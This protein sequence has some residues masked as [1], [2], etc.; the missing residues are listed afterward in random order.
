MKE[1][2]EYVYD[3]SIRGS[4]ETMIK[5][6]ELL[7]AAEEIK[8]NYPQILK[9]L[10]KLINYDKIKNCNHDRL[11][12]SAAY[13]LPYLFD[14][15]LVMT[16]NFDRV[17]EEVFDK[18]HKKFEKVITPYE[19]DL[20]TQSR[21]NNPRCLFKLHGDIGPDIHDIERLIFT[22]TQY[23]RAYANDGPLMQEL[24]QWFQSKKLLFLGCS[25][26]KDKTMGVLQQVTSKNPGLDHYAILACCPGDIPQR[27]IE[28]GNWGISA[29][30]YPDGRHEAVRVILER[31][32]EDTNHSAYEE[33]CRY[34]KKSV[35]AL[36]SANRFMYDSN[37][38][39][40]VG[41]EQEL[42]QLQ[43]FCQDTEQISW[44]AVAGS[45]GIGKSRLVYEFTNAQRE[46]GWKICWLK[47]SDYD[48]LNS[49][50]P[51]VD[52]CIVVMDDVQAH[53]QTIGDWIISISSRQRSEKL[54]I[55]L[56]ERNGKDLDSA[57]WAELMQSESPYDDTISSK[58]YCSDFLNL[59]PL[60]DDELKDIMMD[61]AKVSGKPLVDSEHTDRLL[62]TLK[63]IDGDLQRPIYAL[64]ITDAWCG[65]KDPA[66]WSKEQVLDTL[67]M[68]ELKF[69]YCR[70]CSLSPD[71]ISKETRSE[72]ENLLAQS[73]TVPFL[74]LDQIAD[75]KYPRLHK[76]ADKLDLTFYEMLRQ[77]GI[78]HKITVHIQIEDDES[79]DQVIQEGIMEAIVLDCPDLIKE[80]LVLRQ[81]LNKNQLQLLL[82]K[83][84]VTNPMQLFFLCR[85]LI[86]YP[87]KLE[88][89]NQFWTFFF[90][91]EPE[92]E[93]FAQLYGDLL[94]V[95]TVQIP[96]MKKQA[97][98]RLEKLYYHFHDS[99]DI[100]IKY[101]KGLVN[102]SVDQTLG[103]RVKSV[104]KLRQLYE[105]FPTSTGLML[106]YAK[107]LVNLSVKQ[108]LEDC[109]KSVDKL[110]Q[111][112]EQFPISAE[113]VVAYA[114]G[115]VNLSAE[116]TLGDR[117]K[118]VDKLRQL[119]EQSPTSAELVVE[120]GSG[121]VNLS[122]DQTLGDRVKSV[123]KLRQ[124]YEQ[125]STSA[126]FAVL[127]GK[128]LVNLCA[129]QTLEECT[130]S[131]DKLRLLY[132][133]S[134][135][136]AELAV[137]YGKGLV[138][139]CEKQ[140]LEECTHSVDKLRQLYE[141]SSTSAELAVEYSKGLVNL[142]LKQ[143]EEADVQKN[144][145]QAKKLLSKY[146]KNTD[147]QLSYAQTLFNLTLKQ[148]PETLRQT[149]M[150]LRKFLLAYPE[151]NQGFQNALDTYLNEHP[152]HTE[153][154]TSLRV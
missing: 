53:L 85:I 60:S 111:L 96:K 36:N 138:N 98:D 15:S 91:G 45:G 139:L 24:P 69:Y 16:T 141:Q 52:R 29:I 129:D 114:K 84:W 88:G 104:D 153:R 134:P 72:L 131:V 61:F 59:A 63:K 102:L 152:D 37:Y 74:Q 100:A 2:A 120:Y 56:L 46:V 149:V 80:Y 66:H 135:T 116:Q 147:I 110:R 93:F 83:D 122:V 126:E 64:A 77:I 75:D 7:Q 136:S 62:R 105:Q 30:Y 19:P 87:E 51:P 99:E 41:R 89:N 95:T 130:H 1:L 125:S 107:G 67:V 148:E 117:V 5:N 143:T 11:Y 71:K 113:L 128:G 40:F 28:L 151:A 14:S 144:A 12:N 35:P 31:L 27:C 154:Y 140:T 109:V 39:T 6:G 34:T 127:Y 78:V 133:Q 101:G 23:D 54:R 142:S 22:K 48:N 20:L 18:C 49:W 108:T 86:D 25:L 57:K 124:L 38:I 115:L 76:I 13:V 4:I 119:Y 146:R 47:H 81:T 103:D 17:L 10:Q 145:Q 3:I 32:L 150:Q 55:I 50:T 26:A 97:L 118:S 82:P 73:C 90:A 70:L 58:C 43:E 94:Y 112:Y 44:W 92:L 65:G 123:D 121:L 137:E 33:L 132:E 8:N 9:A 21:Q 79:N 42:A 106:E 68:R